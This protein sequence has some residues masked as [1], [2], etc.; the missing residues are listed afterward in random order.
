LVV[1]ADDTG[2]DV[3][4]AEEQADDGALAGARRTDQ[5]IRLTRRNKERHLL[6]DW[7]TTND[8]TVDH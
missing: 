8:S 4:E 7:L 2:V 3:V 1:D 5:S 6:E